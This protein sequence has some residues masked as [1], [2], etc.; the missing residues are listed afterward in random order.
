MAMP[1]V[2]WLLDV[3]RGGHA[4]G[5]DD[6][7]WPPT[8]SCPPTSWP[9]SHYAR[10][11]FNGHDPCSGHRSH[12]AG[13]SP[14]TLVV[15]L[16]A[17]TSISLSAALAGVLLQRI[18]IALCAIPGVG[19]GALGAVVAVP[20]G[21]WLLAKFGDAAAV[22]REGLAAVARGEAAVRVA[23]PGLWRS[24][25]AFWSGVRRKR[26]ASELPAECVDGTAQG[27]GAMLAA[28]WG[29]ERCRDADA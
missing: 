3:H 24:T 1:R 22:W 27:R 6:A 11:C 18:V 2:D 23:A 10:G 7:A 20:L 17:V 21:A 26:L 16:L 29:R 25:S 13:R 15:G 4:A 12:C 19:N 14:K 5:N 28:A 8:S 9:S